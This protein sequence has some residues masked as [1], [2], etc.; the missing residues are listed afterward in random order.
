M[1]RP[2]NH[3]HEDFE[4]WAWLE[5][6][7]WPDHPHTSGSLR[8]AYDTRPRDS[9][10]KA[11]MAVVEGEIVG[12]VICSEP[13]VYREPGTYR[14]YVV[15]HPNLQRRG[16]GHQLYDCGYQQL[17]QDC[18]IQ[19]LTSSS[20]E[21]KTDALCFLAN[22]GFVCILREPMSE[23]DLANFDPG[24][25]RSKQDQVRSQ[26]IQV[27]SLQE[28][29]AEY[30]DW[31]ERYWKLDL[32]LSYDVP[33]PTP[34]TPQPMDEWVKARCTDP[35]FDPAT[36]W[37][38][39]WGEE[40]VGMTELWITEAAP[41]RAST[42]LTGVIRPARRQGIATA[43]KLQA[44]QYAQDQGIKS[45]VT[46]NE[47]NNPMYQL[48]LALGFTPLPAWLTFRKDLTSAG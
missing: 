26:G 25:H 22:R 38:A 20:R 36:R 48:N 11:H 30:E 12:I 8:H 3:T 39:L 27:R 9:Y 19:A 5:S 24:P 32:T 23:L 41:D 33:S 47:E 2:F 42:D 45:I 46:D 35:D 13:P 31:Q 6:A 15:V 1:L 10:W 28:L 4:A 14:I 34:F 16:I 21:D 37:I 7:I 18:P 29:A 17:R 40:W 43:L 44:I